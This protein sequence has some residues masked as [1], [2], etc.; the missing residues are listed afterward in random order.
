[1]GVAGWLMFSVSIRVVGRA[2]LLVIAPDGVVLL[3]SFARLVFL[4]GV[5]VAVGARFARSEG[6][7]DA[8]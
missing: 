6:A 5:H 1:M 2:V 8:E 3:D 7:C 4:G